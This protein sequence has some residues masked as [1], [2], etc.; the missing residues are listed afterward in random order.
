MK[1]GPASC[2]RRMSWPNKMTEDELSKIELLTAR[3]SV[4]ARPGMYV[5]S[6][7]NHGKL[8]IALE[9]LGNAVDLF[10]RGD[11]TTI[12]VLLHQD[13]SLIHI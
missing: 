11:A 6:R 13:L 5:G 12:S 2:F 3:E 4:R 10:L 7:G 8:H 9:L 1:P